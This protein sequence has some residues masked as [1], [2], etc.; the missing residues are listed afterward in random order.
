MYPYIEILLGA[1]I[2]GDLIA[3]LFFLRYWMVTGDR[4]FLYFAA[5]FTLGAISRVIIDQN[6]PPIGMEAFGYVVRLCSYLVIIVAVID[7]NRIGV[8][9][10]QA[11]AARH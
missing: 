5:S 6:L 2:M 1:I 9:T 11:V 10:T 8:R 4:F 7:K 3:S